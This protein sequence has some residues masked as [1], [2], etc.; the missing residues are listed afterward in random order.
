MPRRTDRN[1]CFICNRLLPYAQA[2]ELCRQCSEALLNEL[3]DVDEQVRADMQAKYAEQD[4]KRNLAAIRAIRKSVAYGVDL[5]SSS[6]VW[7][8]HIMTPGIL[9]GLAQI[10]DLEIE[11]LLVQIKTVQHTLTELEEK[12]KYGTVVPQEG[13]LMPPDEVVEPDAEE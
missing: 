7:L 6:N 11:N 2:G 12:I 3:E 1:R 5:L 13:T 10:S 9:H 8:L 4:R